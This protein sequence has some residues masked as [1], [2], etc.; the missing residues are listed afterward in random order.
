MIAVF[1]SPHTSGAI[2]FK[3]E[4]LYSR[5]GFQ[6]TDSKGHSGSVT[7]DYLMIPQMMTANITRFVQLQAGIFAGYLLRSKDSN[8]PSDNSS[9]SVYDSY[10]S[11]MNRI[12]YGAAGGIEIH[13]IKGL[14]L[15]ARYNMGF[16]KL[17]KKEQSNQSTANYP[18]IYPLPFQN[19]DTKNAVL[20]FSAGYQF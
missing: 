18:M 17:Y 8:E 7:N 20:Q 10:T 19:I 16:A 15:N 6:Y 9:S 11:L 5:Q 13:P 1:L 2:G 4:L 14:T 3:H 12:D